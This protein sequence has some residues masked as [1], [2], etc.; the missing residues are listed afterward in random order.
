MA[1]YRAHLPQLDGRLFVTDGGLE[2]T[3]I[4]HD[5]LDLPLFAAFTL[6]ESES[7]RDSLVRYFHTY[8]ALARERGAGAVLESPTWRANAEW[9]AK[10]GYDAA[11]LARANTEAMVLLEGIRREYDTDATP[12][13]VS[14]CVGPRGD[15]YQ[16]GEM[17]SA[18]TATAFHA[19][20]IETFAASHADLVTALTMTYADEAVGV[21]R[22]AQAAGMPVVLSFTVE[23]DG[24][25][26]DGSPLGDAIARVDDATGGAPTYYMINCAHP[27]HFDTVLATGGSWRERVRGLRANASTKSHAELDAADTLD[28]GDPDDLARRYRALRASLPRL[29]VLGGCCGTDHRHVAAACDAWVDP[30]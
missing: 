25:L 12:V 1:R 15:G 23:T 27:S 22:A 4:F 19:P 30:S 24:A 3:L 13:V 20:Q 21:A 18:E 17:M 6:L 9:G 2:T 28:D 5:G 11:K 16:A 14:G 8:A 7:G 29:N 10:L 26:P